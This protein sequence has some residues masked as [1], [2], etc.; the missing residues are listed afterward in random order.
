MHL[1]NL[2]GPDLLKGPYLGTF[3]HKIILRAIKRHPNQ[4]RN[5]SSNFTAVSCPGCLWISRHRPDRSRQS[6]RPGNSVSVCT[7]L[8]GSSS[9]LN[10]KKLSVWTRSV[11]LYK[12]RY[13]MSLAFI[14]TLGKCGCFCSCCCFW[15]I[16]FL[17]KL[18]T[19][20]NLG[21]LLQNRPLYDLF[22]NVGANGC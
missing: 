6:E 17:I 9:S 18:S 3:T 5:Q 21:S 10:M 12:S 19:F 20:K 14:V 2:E 8:S 11:N 4:M 16:P 13:R 7:R 15:L 22:Q 1:R